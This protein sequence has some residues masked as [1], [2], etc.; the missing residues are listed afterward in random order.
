MI[1]NTTQD[2][3]LVKRILLEPFG[4]SAR[5]FRFFVISHNLAAAIGQ[6]ESK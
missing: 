4:F 2:F 1:F 6:N 3:A 5:F